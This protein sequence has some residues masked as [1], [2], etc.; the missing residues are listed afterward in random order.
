MPPLFDA[1][2][3][4]DWSAAA[5][6]VKG[7]NSI[8]ICAL[9]RDARGILKSTLLNPSTRR[10][11]R[12][13]IY[14]LASDFVARGRRV[15]IGFDFAMGYPAGTARALGLD[16]ETTP[17]WRTMHD[18]L[19]RHIVDGEDN[20]NNRFALAASM[21]A[22]MTGKAHPFWG[23]PASKTAPTLAASKGDF[24]ASG[25]LAEH[26]RAERWIRTQYSAHPKTVWQLL[27]AGAVGSQSL[28][29]IAA[30]AYL[31]DRLPGAAVWPFETGFGEVTRKRLENTSCI[32]AEIYPS[33]LSISP[34][35]GEILDQAQVR[36]LSNHFESLDSAGL[37][38][39]AF[40]FPDSISDREIHKIIGEEGWILAK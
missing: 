18:Y 14:E 3:M 32:L 33:T 31:R 11:A 17:P 21:N 2:I 13:T 16:I 4:V 35:T 9:A 1:Y 40:D 8:W 5:R 27:G 30:V 7:V 34:K 28:L 25:S 20:S 26:R 38:G 15:L 36:S 37:L 39:S 10:L 23:A 22:A 6:P 24:S 12:H 29:G 19:A